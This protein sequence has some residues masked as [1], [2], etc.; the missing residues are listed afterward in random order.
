MSWSRRVIVGE[1]STLVVIAYPDDSVAQGAIST[2]ESLSIEEFIDLEDTAYAV[3]GSDET[4]KFHETRRATG[5]GTAGGGVRGVLTRL[6]FFGSSA[7]ATGGALVGRYAE[8]GI[9][10]GFIE[11]LSETLEPGGTAVFMLVRSST[12]DRV[13]AE[14]SKFGG[15]VIKTSLPPE[16]E[17]QLK[18]ELAGKDP[19]P[20]DL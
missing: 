19:G 11:Y 17:E 4:V 15:T 10:E 1:E 2:L 9:D 7:G 13:I 20:A 14:M 18:E 12:R 3:K 8:L 5:A 16:L 6:P